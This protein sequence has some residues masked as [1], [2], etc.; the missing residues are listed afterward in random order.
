MFSSTKALLA[1][2]NLTSLILSIF[3]PLFVLLLMIFVAI[4]Y[5]QYRSRPVV[6]QNTTKSAP[7]TISGSIDLDGYVPDGSS[8]TITQRLMGQGLFTPVVSGI[9]AKDTAVWAWNA[10][11]YGLAYDLQANI[12]LNGKIIAQ[13]K[14]LTIAA[15]AEEETLRIVSDIPAPLKT[16]TISGKINLNGYVPTGATITVLARKIGETDYQTITSGIYPSD[17]VTWDFNNAYQGV[18]YEVEALLL[19]NGVTVARSQSLVVAAPANYEELTINSTATPPGPTIVSISGQLDVNGVVPPNSVVVIGER[20]SGTPQF[21]IVTTGIPVVDGS[22]WIWNAATAGKSYDIQAYVQVGG[23]TVSQSQI[24]TVAAPAQNEILTLNLPL[25]PPSPPQNS[26]TNT[27][28]G[29]GPNGLWQVQINYNINNVVSSIQQYSLTVGTNTG[30][31]QLVNITTQPANINAPNQ[32]QSYTT[33]YLFTE[34]QTYFAQWAYATCSNCSNFSSYSPSLQFYCQTPPTTIP[35][36]IPSA[37]PIPTSIPV[38]SAT[39][40]PPTATSIPLSPTPPPPTNG[41]LK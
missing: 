22:T 5:M 10:A 38:P 41:L 25:Q 29:K 2:K 8:I 4:F 18:T 3:I 28:V 39:P 31:S 6:T 1:N 20:M 19:L 9:E 24:L 36:P 40:V 23:V 16:S 11:Q 12:M 14:I 17:G 30:G 32:T 26:M 7:T 34:G 15:P 35:T 13:S 27:C 33:G 37:T 21:S